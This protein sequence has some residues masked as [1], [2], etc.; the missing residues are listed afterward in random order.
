MK[1]WRTLSSEYTA[2]VR[3]QLRIPHAANDG[4]HER[5]P[6]KLCGKCYEKPSKAE[7]SM[8][9]ENESCAR[10]RDEQL[11]D[12]QQEDLGWIS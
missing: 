5:I 9:I 3:R 1:S 2:I 8:S 6:K 4:T 7:E 11:R 10:K 12:A